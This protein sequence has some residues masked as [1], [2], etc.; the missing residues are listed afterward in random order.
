MPSSLVP[1]WRRDAERV[2]EGQEAGTDGL[3]RPRFAEVAEDRAR[4]DARK[5][6]G[7]AEQ[8]Q[9]RAGAQRRQKRVEHEQVGHGRFVDHDDIGRDGGVGAAAPGAAR[10]RVPEQ[11]VQRDRL[12]G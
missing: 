9:S 12:D 1:L 8:H 11:P 7:I 2:A 10:G 5:L 4:A 6:I 3:A